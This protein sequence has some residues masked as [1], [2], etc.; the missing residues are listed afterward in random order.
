MK[1]TIFCMMIAI[2]T[3]ICTTESFGNTHDRNRRTPARRHGT[4]VCT[5]CR[6]CN[7]GN[8]YYCTSAGHMY[9]KASKTH[10]HKTYKNSNKCKYCKRYVCTRPHKSP[11]R[12]R[13]TF[14]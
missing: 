6:K 12:Q 3:V 11:Q 14:R 7:T 1:K 4:A 5:N 10:R 9:C 13:I 2:M 8:T